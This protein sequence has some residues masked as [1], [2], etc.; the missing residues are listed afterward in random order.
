MICCHHNPSLSHPH[1]RGLLLLTRTLLLRYDA[2]TGRKPGRAITNRLV[3]PG[4][5]S[6]PYGCETGQD[7]RQVACCSSPRPTCEHVQRA[8][9][10]GAIH[11]DVGAQG[12]AP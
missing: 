11:K 5:V 4:F 7:A 1:M 9:F 8:P 6:K 12:R 10:V 2:G 3:A